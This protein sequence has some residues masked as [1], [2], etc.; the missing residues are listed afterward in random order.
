MVSSPKGPRPNHKALLVLQRDLKKVIDVS[1]L[2]QLQRDIAKTLVRLEMHFL[3]T[4]FDIS[5]HMLIHLVDQ[6]RALGLMYLHQMFPF[7]RLIKV[8]R[9]YI[10]NRF[11]LEGGMVEGWSHII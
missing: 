9:R 11:R 10:R 2:E 4:Y 6:I 3:P 5:L 7:E 1:T 8:F